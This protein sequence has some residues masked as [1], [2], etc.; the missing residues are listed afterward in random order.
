[1]NFVR[2]VKITLLIIISR[3]LFKK[4]NSVATKITRTFL[5][6]LKDFGKCLLI[7]FLETALR[8]LSNCKYKN[9]IYVEVMSHRVLNEKP[10]L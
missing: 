1:M 2:R 4:Q 9:C 7:I 5:Y 6:F 10:K 8:R 3:H